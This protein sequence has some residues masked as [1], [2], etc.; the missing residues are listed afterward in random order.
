MARDAWNVNGSFLLLGE[1]A[2]VNDRSRYGAD[3]RY[4]IAKPLLPPVKGYRLH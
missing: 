3:D 4:G 2:V 1:L